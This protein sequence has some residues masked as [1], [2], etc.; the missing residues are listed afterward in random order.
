MTP[1]LGSAAAP[2]AAARSGAGRCTTIID[3]L[4]VIGPPKVDRISVSGVVSG[5]G[6]ISVSGVSVSGVSGAVF[7]VV[8]CVS[9][10]FC[11]SGAAG[12]A[13]AIVG[14]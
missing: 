13:D 3:F 2:S 7:C 14:P 4:L 10:V 6:A 11:V 8:F 12:A 1:N 9:E 5:A